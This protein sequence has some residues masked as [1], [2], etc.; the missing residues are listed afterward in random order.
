MTRTRRFQAPRV[1]SPRAR[2]RRYALDFD[3]AVATLV[4]EFRPQLNATTAAYS[5]HA[6]AV[7]RLANGHT[8][9]AFSCD[10]AL[11]GA[12]CTHMVYEADASGAE[13]ARV[14]VPAVAGALAAAVLP[15]WHAA[16]LAPDHDAAGYRA[17]PFETL[18]GERRID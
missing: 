6:G 4:W 14:R 16:E 5:F 17:L 11:A 12:G 2:G 18:A 13:L 7:A 9:G 15:P 10:S 1:P 8:V 3:G